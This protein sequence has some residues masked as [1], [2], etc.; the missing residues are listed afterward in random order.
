[1]MAK[2]RLQ[3]PNKEVE[4]IVLVYHEGVN[5]N[6]QLMKDLEKKYLPS[7]VSKEKIKPKT[8]QQLC[9][10]SKSNQIVF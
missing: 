1:M 2:C 4:A 8:P 7:I 6:S 5:E 9:Q 3:K 10:G